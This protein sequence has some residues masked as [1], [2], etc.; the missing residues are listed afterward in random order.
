MIFSLPAN[1]IVNNLI[2][3]RVSKDVEKEVNETVVTLKEQ[4]STTGIEKEYLIKTCTKC[5][6]K[7]TNLQVMRRHERV[8][9]GVITGSTSPPTKRKRKQ[10]K[11]TTDIEGMDIEEEG[12]VSDI[13]LQI[14]DMDIDD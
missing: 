2:R 7:A 14:E 8:T 11:N 9:H 3:D 5:D 4:C 13:S 12:N 1:D 10:P 6:Y